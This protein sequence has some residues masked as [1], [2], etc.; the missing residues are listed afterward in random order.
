MSQSAPH[1]PRRVTGF[2]RF[3]ASISLLCA[4]IL[5]FAIHYGHAFQYLR[6]VLTFTAVLFSP[7]YCVAWLCDLLAFRRRSLRDQIPWAICLSFGL[8]GVVSYI[9]GKS[10]SVD[11]LLAFCIVSA[12]ASAVLVGFKLK[13]SGNIEPGSAILQ[14]KTALIA[15]FGWIAFLA[16]ELL[17]IAFRGRMYLNVAIYDLSRRA[18]FVDAVVRTGVT[19]A[20]PLFWPGHA[21][22]MRYYYFWN[23]V[24]AAA[25]RLAAIPASQAIVASVAWAGIGI[26]SIVYLY[27]QEFLPAPTPPE[28]E[29]ANSGR[30]GRP[31]LAIAMLAVTGLDLL[32]TILRAVSGLPLHPDMEWWSLDQVTSWIDSVIWV[33]HHV[34]GLVCCLQGFLLIWLSKSASP[35]QRV[36]C[37]IVA[38]L[39]FSSALGTSIWV[40]LG[41]ALAMVAW[42]VWTLATRQAR[43]RVLALVLAGIVAALAS[44]PYVH[45]L[46]TANTPSS[47]KPTDNATAPNQ[48]A[49][50]QPRFL[51]LRLRHILD[52]TDLQRF[53]PYDQFV[54]HHPFA[55]RPLWILALMLL[56]IIPGYAIE[57]GFYGIVLIIAW[58]A[59]RALEIDEASRTCLFLVAFIL[60]FTSFFGS[61]VI[62][63]ND[64]GWRATLIA[65]FF[66]LLL[67][68]RWM[69]GAYGPTRRWSRLLIS[70]TICLGV[71]GSIYQVVELRTYLPV[72]DE[73][74]RPFAAGIGHQVFGLDQ[75]FDALHG[76][77]PRNAV[78]QFN[79]LEPKEYVDYAEIMTV[80][81]Q[82]AA[83][84]TDCGSDFGGDA[85]KCAPM[86]QQIAQLFAVAG[87]PAPSS[88]DALQACRSLG[89]DYLIASRWDPAW[90]DRGGW[91][92]QLPA[93]VD[94][95]EVR[96][97][98][99]SEQDALK[100]IESR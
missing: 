70:I 35:I 12:G 58:R 10:L 21:A 3:D 60:L 53:T 6:G 78:V 73:L 86:E 95:G 31:A 80:G 23:I 37:A 11:A 18:A 94:T 79:S 51:T 64:F 74:G 88:S 96:V 41:F 8:M 85:K 90:E 61:R 16:A 36:A 17:N 59:K 14:S 52:P 2:G 68:V 55:A 13:T 33:P 71:A 65:Q 84:Q 44:R 75:A 92:W 42:A 57:L 98:R 72:Q 76:A 28:S 100:R 69:E 63:M 67:A 93:V 25:A 77:V 22:P 49:S 97:L 87:G 27:C 39:A 5:A 9:V 81:R 54:Q 46:Q 30:S 89:A 83:G 66:L 32:P 26:A 38:G 50:V 19:P 45:E 7:G 24:T 34:A 62:T 4:A 56:L 99:C 48:A 29:A 91:V 47:A 20:N 15:L 82:M 1:A 40:A 43:I